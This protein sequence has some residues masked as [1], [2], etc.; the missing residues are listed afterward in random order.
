MYG[1]QAWLKTL[2]CFFSSVQENFGFGTYYGCYG[3]IGG[4]ISDV[5]GPYFPD[6][7]WGRYQESET[8]RNGCMDQNFRCPSTT[9]KR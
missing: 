6:V 5:D 4:L 1:W 2:Y 3:V 7:P 8:T 9:R